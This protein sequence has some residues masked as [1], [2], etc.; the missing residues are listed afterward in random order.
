M[1][2]RSAYSLFKRAGKKGSTYYARFWS[3]AEGR[4]VKTVALGTSKVGLAR[5]RAANLLRQGIVS[6][7]DNPVVLDYLKEFWT[8]GSVYG[9][10]KAL[11]GRPLSPRYV[12]LC[13]S[14]VRLY[15]EPWKPFGKLRVSELTPNALEKWMLWMQD[16][17]KG[18]RTSNIALQ[19][20]R[21]AV[22]RWARLRRLAD[23][24]EGFQ[25]AAETTRGRGS[26]ALAELRALMEL[27]T[28]KVGNFHEPQPLDPRVRAGVLIS[29]LAGLRLGECRGLRWE[30]VDD[31]LGVISVRRSI[32]ADEKEPRVPKWGSTGE[33]P[34]PEILMEELRALAGSS[35]LGREGYVLYAADADAPISTNTL[36]DGFQKMLDAIGLDATARAERRLSFHSLRH[37]FVSLSRLSGIPDFL[38]QRFARHKSAVMMEQ[39]THANILDMAEARKK[40][41]AAFKIAK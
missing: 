37:S 38:V 39:Y 5:T 18:A 12:E 26:L 8:E 34:A 11:R 17:G 41:D 9:R 28:V 20:L 19:A 22:R 13:R 7:E 24:L 3:E 40:L 23:P 10:Q 16:E 35:P 4:Y 15:I 2:K 33:V 25:K 29:C 1:S 36:R 14:A 30:D 31:R 6:N 32:S 27:K 21:V